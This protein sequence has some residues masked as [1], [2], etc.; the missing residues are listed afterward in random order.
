VTA[1]TMERA[2]PAAA[3]ALDEAVP[4][5]ALHDPRTLKPGQLCEEQREAALRNALGLK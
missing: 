3:A 5:S 2:A 1:Q 4:E